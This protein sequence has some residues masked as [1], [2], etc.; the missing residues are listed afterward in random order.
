[1]ASLRNTLAINIFDGCSIAI[2]ISAPGA[3]PTSLMVSGP[4]MADRRLLGIAKSIE[5]LL[6]K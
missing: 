6:A 2:P 4:P 1:M 3:P 5:N